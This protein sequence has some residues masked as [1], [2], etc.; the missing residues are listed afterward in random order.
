MVGLTQIDSLRASRTSL[1][2]PQ[3][4]LMQNILGLQFSANGLP[5]CGLRVKGTRRF[6][7]NNS[8]TT[9]LKLV[10]QTF[11]VRIR[12][13]FASKRTN[14]HSGSSVENTQLFAPGRRP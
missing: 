7:S 10:K 9:L 12:P 6:G 14:I 1:S 4:R 3:R 2:Q 8:A 5:S 13:G 11:F